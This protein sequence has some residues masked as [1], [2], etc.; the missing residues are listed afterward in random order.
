MTTYLNV[1]QYNVMH[2]ILV[3]TSNILLAIS[4]EIIAHFDE[5][6]T[7]LFLDSLIVVA[8]AVFLNEVRA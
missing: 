8:A 5:L 7:I 6:E 3:G 1:I 4:L 2:M